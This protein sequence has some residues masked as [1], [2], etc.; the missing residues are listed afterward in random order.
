MR[1]KEGITLIAL[2]VEII[3]IIILAGIT[4]NLILGQ[5]GIIKKT[6]QAKKDYANAT[7]EEEEILS[8]AIYDI[9]IET[10]GDRRE[11]TEWVLADTIASPY[12]PGDYPNNTYMNIKKVYNRHIKG[13]MV[14]F[15][16]VQ[17]ERRLCL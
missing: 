10:E 7:V 9:E 6:E 17:L 15:K 1:K 12:Y 8:N 14:V 16:D 5:G 2:V 11:E 4:T 3:I 13:I